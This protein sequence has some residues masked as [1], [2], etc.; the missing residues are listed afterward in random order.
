MENISLREPKPAFKIKG[1]EYFHVF[2][3]AVNI[4]DVIPHGW[5]DMIMKIRFFEGIPGTGSK[6]VRSKLHED[7][8]EMFSARSNGIVQNAGDR[9][10]QNRIRGC[11]P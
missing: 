6:V 9:N 10:L 1:T 11:A 2:D 8:H 3:N 7:I 4:F 5:H